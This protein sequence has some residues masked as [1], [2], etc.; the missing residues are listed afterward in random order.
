MRNG[1]NATTA[2][3]KTPFAFNAPECPRPFAHFLVT[4]WATEEVAPAKLQPAAAAFATRIGPCMLQPLADHLARDRASATIRIPDGAVHQR[5][6]L[7][8]NNF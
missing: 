1:P 4:P 7:G 6:R 3:T 2:A 5:A 8:E